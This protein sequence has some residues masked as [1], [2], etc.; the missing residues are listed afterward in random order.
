M[1]LK[2]LY[3][4]CL[5]IN[6]S[7]ILLAPKQKKDKLIQ[8]FQ[9]AEG[10]VEECYGYIYKFYPK[11]THPRWHG[12]N[13]ECCR[14]KLTSDKESIDK[15]ETD[16]QENEK[17]VIYQLPVEP[18]RNIISTVLQIRKIQNRVMSEQQQNKTNWSH[19]TLKIPY[20]SNSDKNPH[21]SARSKR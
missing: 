2:I 5:G 20:N 1:K 6:T 9:L 13:W 21:F 19:D 10:K 12:S 17:T 7:H 18:F 16:E 15:V 8:E 14:I 3:G 11:L 4:L